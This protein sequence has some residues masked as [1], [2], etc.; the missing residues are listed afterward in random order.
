MPMLEATTTNKQYLPTTRHLIDL[1][2]SLE[3]RCRLAG[4]A[5]VVYGYHSIINGVARAQ[6]L[7]VYKGEPK[8]PDPKGLATLIDVF[9]QMQRIG[10]DEIESIAVEACASAA[11]IAAFSKWS[12]ETPPSIYLADGTPVTPQ[13]GSKVT[14]TVLRDENLSPDD[15]TRIRRLHEI[16]VT[17]RFK[18]KSL[19]D[20]VT[21]SSCFNNNTMYRIKF[22][23]F[24]AQIQ[25]M[26]VGNEWERKAIFAAVPFA[27][28]LVL[29]QFQSEGGLE[30]GS[31]KHRSG[32]CPSIP[33]LTARKPSPF[34]E[35]GKIFRTMSLVLGLPPDFPSEILASVKSFRDLQ[36]VDRYFDY[37]SKSNNSIPLLMA[38]MPIL[39][40]IFE[41]TLKDIRRGTDY[42]SEPDM[43]KLPWWTKDNGAQSGYRAWLQASKVGSFLSKMRYTNSA[44]VPPTSRS[45]G[46]LINALSFTCHIIL[47]LS[48]FDNL[49]DMLFVPPR[50]YL[51]YHTSGNNLRL[52]KETLTILL[53]ARPGNI[54]ASTVFNNVCL[55]LLPEGHDYNFVLVRSGGGNCF[56]FS[57]LDAPLHSDRG[58]LSITS[59]RGR[60]IH[61]R[62]LYNTVYDGYWTMAAD[63]NT[64]NVEQYTLESVSHQ[65]F[66]TFQLRWRI[67][68]SRA[69]L[70]AN[71]T[72]IDEEG[73]ETTY[74][75][76]SS[77]KALD[78][79]ADALVVNCEHAVESSLDQSKVEQKLRSVKGQ[80]MKTLSVPGE[81]SSD[82]IRIYP[83]GGNRGLQMYCLGCIRIHHRIDPRIGPKPPGVILRQEACFNCCM[84]ACEEYKFNYLIL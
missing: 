71:L 64:P 44:N 26:L 29:E 5:D 80:F 84:E 11:W 68:A 45:L 1:M 6:G 72:V 20:L 49:T 36:E 48:L 17:K 12:L 77:L 28:R 75:P 43:W 82:I 70:F 61:G 38:D 66:S 56:W 10:E 73:T 13:P 67:T 30:L 24:S 57:T 31:R 34:P 47:L 7:Q 21:E 69:E 32:D 9:R 4:F 60:I 15:K 42:K 58:Y 63:G 65:P 52:F 18:I 51:N 2:S 79:L 54:N 50:H 39:E 3:G 62:D 35:I 78:T 19:Q 23:T 14:L 46:E 40:M 33:P 8:V 25:E 22:E 41:E 37:T 59:C 74:K 55:V 81:L 83:M 53:G 76:Y 27:I 16:K